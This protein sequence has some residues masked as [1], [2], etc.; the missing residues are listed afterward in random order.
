MLDWCV[1]LGAL[2]AGKRI[3]RHSVECGMGKNR[4]VENLLINMY[5]KC[6]ALEEA[7]KIL[8][9]M[10]DSNVFSWT[11]MLAAYAQNGL[12]SAKRV[13]DLSHAKRDVVSWNSMLSTCSQNEQGI[14]GTWELFQQMDLEGFQPDRVTFV[15]LLDCCASFADLRRGR[16]VHQCAV[17]SGMD[18]LP[19]V[20]NC[21][22]NMYGKCDD[23]EEARRVFESLKRKNEI[24]WSSLVAAYAQNNQATEAMKLFQHMDLEGLKPDRVTLISVLDACGDLR[25]SKQSS[26]IHARVLEADLE[27]DVVVANALVSMYGKLGRLE[28]ATVIFETM[29]EK[30]RDVIAWNAMISAYA[31]TGH[32]TRA[33]GIFR[34]MLL[35]AAVTPSA[36]TISAIL[37]A[38]LDLGSGRR[39]HC[40]A[41]SIGVESHPSVAIS[42]L[43]MYSRCSS[44]ITSARALF[45]GMERKSLVAWNTM[46]AACA[47][48]GLAAEAQELFKAMDVEPDGFTF[49]SLL[50]VCCDLD[51]GR[52]LHA[53][54]A[55]ARLA[56]RLIVDTALVGMYSRCGSLGDA[57]AV[58][59][60][61]ED[62]DTC[63]SLG[64]AKLVFDRIPDKDAVSWNSMISAY[65]HHGRYKDAIATYRAMDCRPDEAT[66]V[67][68]L[69]AASA[70]ADLDEGAAIHAR[71]LELGIATP[72]VESTL[73]SMHAK[74]GSL[75]AAM[76]L[77]EKNREKDLVSWNAMVAAYAQHGDGSEALALIHRMELE[78]ISPNGVTLSG[79]LASCSHAGLLER[80][81]FYVGWLSREHGVAVESEHYRFVVELLGRCGR[82]GEAEAVVRGMPLEPEPALWVTLV[83]ACVLHEEV[84]R[85][86]RAAAGLDPGDAASYVLLANVYSAGI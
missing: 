14:Q 36:A 16:Q 78:G 75:D 4:F 56:S 77:F 31:H 52:R 66:I 79:V 5:G 7:R 6:G 65:A 42:L 24:S 30:S 10:E 15:T 32:H 55:T 13:F 76:A 61:M 70:L 49:A 11:I 33:F 21:V 67:S 58:F 26:Q 35:E 81:M 28:Q 54:I 27:R 18:L 63:G 48:R 43:G 51:L 22:V 1:R 64:D 46:I 50:A 80:G 59:E 44:S 73:A 45:L 57:A 40:L 86:D 37:A 3:H 82:L 17:A 72:A 39:I 62:R 83:A 8:D 12:D 38:C 2:E 19:T 60:G 53:G 71:A 84:S 20:A 9:G 47:Q 85:A 25:A 23:L 34:I 74:C 29:G 68:A 69:A 41:A